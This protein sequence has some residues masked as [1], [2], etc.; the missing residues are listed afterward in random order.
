V[1]RLTAALRDVEATLLDGVG[2]AAV[3]HD[4]QQFAAVV[5]DFLARIDRRAGRA[6]TTPGG[7]SSAGADPEPGAAGSTTRAETAQ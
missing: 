3:D 1:P 5:A 4:P 6:A 7:T 2:V